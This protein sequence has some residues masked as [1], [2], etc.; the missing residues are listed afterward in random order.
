MV[1]EDL[2]NIQVVCRE[3]IEERHPNRGK[4][5]VHVG[6]LAK[7]R[8]TDADG[9]E[10][11]WVE[12]EKENGDKFEGKLR[13]DPVLLWRLSFGDNVSFGKEDVWDVMVGKYENGN[14]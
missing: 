10:Y 8:F 5:D 11:M 4:F 6:N 1:E 9:T 12:V 7:V 3:C 2:K 13:N 14:A